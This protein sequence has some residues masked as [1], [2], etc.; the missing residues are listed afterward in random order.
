MST[1]MS[2]PS[3]PSES[4]SECELQNAYGKDAPR[5]VRAHR[6]PPVCAAH[7]ADA[8]EVHFSAAHRLPHVPSGH[9]DGRLHGHNYRV[10]IHFSGPI[11]PHTGWVVDFGDVKRLWEPLDATLDHRYLNE[12][13]GLDNPTTEVVARWIYERLQPALPGLVEVEVWETPRACCRYRVV[14]PS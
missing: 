3:A 7:C 11:D 13:E 8:V 12:V 6:P 4:G 1:A 2:V 9:K 5:G 14:Q 10:L